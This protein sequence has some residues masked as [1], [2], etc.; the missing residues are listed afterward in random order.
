MKT[1]AKS[2]R[3]QAATHNPSFGNFG[4]VTGVWKAKVPLRLVQGRNNLVGRDDLGGDLSLILSDWGVDRNDKDLGILPIGTEVRIEHLYFLDTYETCTLMA[5]TGSLT[6]GPY[7]NRPLELNGRF[8]EKDLM[9]T[10]QLDHL[11]P[12]GANVVWTV[13]SDILEK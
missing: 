11:N 6:A 10:V 3:V 4:A 9:A 13:N 7:I 1:L 8:F 5:A 12:G 2:R